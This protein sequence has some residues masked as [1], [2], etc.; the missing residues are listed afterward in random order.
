MWT[1]YFCGSLV[2]IDRFINC[3]VTEPCHRC[4]SLQVGGPSS[5]RQVCEMGTRLM[6]LTAGRAKGQLW[7]SDMSCKER[8]GGQTIACSPPCHFISP[9]FPSCLAWK[10]TECDR[11]FYFCNLSPNIQPPPR[12]QR[13]H[14][15]TFVNCLSPMSVTHPAKRTWQTCVVPCHAWL[16]SHLEMKLEWHLPRDPG[17]LG[18]WLALRRETVVIPYRWAVS[19]CHQKTLMKLQMLTDKFAATLRAG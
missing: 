16:R 14:P 9:A 8:D 12:K 5:W 6:E 3:G 18:V 11:S 10:G 2:L 19:K 1:C 13:Y 17:G 7:A 4:G 15:S